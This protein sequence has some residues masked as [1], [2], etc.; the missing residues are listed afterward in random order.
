MSQ[1]QK[2]ELRLSYSRI[3]TFKSCK[4][5]YY[6]TYFLKTKT[7]IESIYSLLGTCVH[8]ALENGV[9]KNGK[10]IQKPLLLAEYIKSYS[11]E[12]N[13]VYDGNRSHMIVMDKDLRGRPI[14]EVYE[15]YLH[16]G[17]EILSNYYD[18]NKDNDEQE[19]IGKELNFK[20]PVYSDD[21]N[22]VVL[23]GFIDKLL[24]I[25]DSPT[26][27]KV[28]DYK[29]SSSVNNVD[30]PE[31]NLQLKIYDIAVREH[32]GDKNLDAVQVQLDFVRLNKDLVAVYNDDDRK[33]TMEKLY[34]YAKA[35][36]EEHEKYEKGYIPEPE[37]NS[38]CLFCDKR[39]NC[40]LYK[41]N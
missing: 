5:R 14:E 4:Y 18:I 2:K 1:P 28:V 34:F 32:I 41:H 17:I 27:Y 22:Y 33:D 8:S 20:F 16:K 23:I 10:L 40:P 13:R 25:S 7:G 31:E 37:K 38:L 9:L 19:V 24:K 36:I 35:I 30:D 15:K 11:E 39:V 12:F 21:N 3:S 6:E 29:T 26:V